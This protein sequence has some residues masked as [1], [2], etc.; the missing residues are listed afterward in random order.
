MKKVFQNRFSNA[1][2]TNRGNCYAAVIASMMDKDSAD[3]VIQIQ[4]YY[5]NDKGNWVEVLNK[6][7]QDNGY[8]WHG[9]KG[10]SQ[11]KDEFY[12]VSGKSPRF[13]DIYHICVY[14]NGKLYHDPHPDGTGILTEEQFEII[15][16]IKN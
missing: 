6:W 13:P 10:H 4:D 1:E 5:D 11:I 7:L 16:P 14:Q 9:L 15:Q 2:K 8:E 12:L 3:D